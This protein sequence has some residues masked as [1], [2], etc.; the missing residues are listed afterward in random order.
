[1]DALDLIYKY[2]PEDN[3]LRRLLLHH[4]RQVADRALYIAGQRPGLGV[5]TGFVEE[6]ALLHDVGIFLTD[7]PAIHCHGTEPYLVHGYLGGKLMRAEGRPDLARVCERHTGTGLTREDIAA[8]ALPLPPADYL[9][10]TMEEKLVCYADKFYSKSHP[11]RER[12][13]PQ[14]AKSLEKFGTEGAA[15]FLEWARLFEPARYAAEMGH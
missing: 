9:P 4:S 11:E 10:E 5:D 14:T 2:Y 15:K 8:R 6:A 3:A 7:A 1:M 12:T 13:I